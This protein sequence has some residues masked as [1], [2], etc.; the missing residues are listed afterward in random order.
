M[1]IH[2]SEGYYPHAKNY[3]EMVSSHQTRYSHQL[4]KDNWTANDPMSLGTNYYWIRLRIA[5]PITTA[6]IIEQFKLHTN[7]FEVNN[8]GWLEYFGKARPI[9]RLGWEFGVLEKAGGAG[10]D[11]DLY[12]GDEL[13]V[14][15][16]KNR[17]DNGKIAR[18]G[19]NT[20]LPMDLDTS[21]PITFSWNIIA[22]GTGTADVDWILRWGYSKDG[23]NVYPESG[24]PDPA[25]L[26]IYS[27]SLPAPGTDTSKWYSTTLDVSEMVSRREGGYPDTLWFTISRDGIADDYA[28]TISII[29]ISANYIKWCEGGH[30]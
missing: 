29:G 10:D 21:S 9:G 26:Q 7:R 20:V 17:F 22:E 15:M 5:S 18:V 8:D 14:G 27:V 6:P 25:S 1:E 24:H 11:R 28:S 19:F 23:D 30:I 12:L 2:S 3:L 16:K 13:D 4:A